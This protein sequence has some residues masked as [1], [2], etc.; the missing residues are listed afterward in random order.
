MP[1]WNSALQT[2]KPQWLVVYRGTR[3]LICRRMATY[4]VTPKADRSGFTVSILDGEGALQTT[5]GFAREA[6]ADA[7]I[8]QATRMN[9][10]WAPGRSFGKSKYP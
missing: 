9:K 6:D 3:T 10:S 4:T 2:V 5:L 1:E 8:T 7:W